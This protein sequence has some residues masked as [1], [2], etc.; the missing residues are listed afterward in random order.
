MAD[1]V[2]HPAVTVLWLCCAP[3]VTVLCANQVALRWLIQSGTAVIPRAGNKAYQAD[4]LDI[5]DFELSKAEMDTLD[6]Y[7]K[8][9]LA[10]GGGDCSVA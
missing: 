6:A 2:Q 8:P 5:F 4:N 3:A 10:G 7:T 1:P 9:N